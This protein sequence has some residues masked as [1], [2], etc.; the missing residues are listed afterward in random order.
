MIIMSVVFFVTIPDLDSH[1]FYLAAQKVTIGPEYF[2]AQISVF[3]VS[4]YI[5]QLSYPPLSLFIFK[6]LFLASSSGIFIYFLHLLMIILIFRFVTARDMI[7]PVIALQICLL[8]LVS[9][10]I[11]STMPNIL[12]FLFIFIGLLYLF[13]EKKSVIS[14][15]FFLIAIFIS[16]KTALI[17]ILIVIYDF[18]EKK[19]VNKEIL[20]FLLPFG[21]ISI[22]FGVVFLKTKLF[23][24]FEFNKWYGSVRMESVP[25]LVSSF[26]FTLSS[27][28]LLLF[29]ISTAFRQ[30]KISYIIVYIVLIISVFF[31]DLLLTPLI[32][33]SIISLCFTYY[34]LFRHGNK[35][36]V[37]LHALFLLAM[38]VLAPNPGL[39]QFSFLMPLMFFLFNNK[40][41]HRRI[42][43]I[44]L[45]IALLLVFQTA[46]LEDTFLQKKAVQKILKNYE[47]AGSIVSGTASYYSIQRGSSQSTFNDLF[48]GETIYS[49]FDLSKKLLKNKVELLDLV[50]V[51]GKLPYNISSAKSCFY[52]ATTRSSFVIDFAR[53][54]LKYYI[55]KVGRPRVDMR[56]SFP[57]ENV[58]EFEN[59]CLD[60]YILDSKRCELRVYTTFKH[61]T[62]V[63]VFWHDAIGIPSVQRWQ[64]ISK[65]YMNKRGKVEIIIPLPADHD[66]GFLLFTNEALTPFLAKGGN[67]YK[68]KV[69]EENSLE[70]EP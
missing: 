70:R 41:T 51:H 25:G 53:R 47:N 17:L 43:P 5:W 64:Y 36:L 44:A 69:N 67:E 59:F 19:K 14:A 6:T 22:Y 65:E 32:I 9:V 28:G 11:N 31:S 57:P 10:F 45:S 26:I 58:I 18:W 42:L 15:L 29:P 33:L 34:L 68:I 4:A 55:F 20:W 24:P 2:T 21:A 7:S 30:M 37:F 16:Y 38:I 27:F 13:K 61:Y 62:P 48:E 50:E 12:E 40:K 54:S 8:P 46:R 23:I 35:K 3:G 1:I 49:D 56:P 60:G 63:I 66:T 39:K 52:N